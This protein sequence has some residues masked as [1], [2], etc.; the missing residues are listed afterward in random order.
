MGVS[1]KKIDL[2]DLK[3][4][5]LEQNEVDKAVDIFRE[6]HLDLKPTLNRITIKTKA[7]K[8]Y[9]GDFFFD[10]LMNFEQQLPQMSVADNLRFTSGYI[11]NITRLINLCPDYYELYFARARI[12]TAA[13]AAR[14]HFLFEKKDSID[15]DP[16]LILLK[17]EISDS[18]SIVR[19]NLITTIKL[20]TKF[21]MSNPYRP[22]NFYRTEI[23]GILAANY[24]RW[25]FFIARINPRQSA[26]KETKEEI[27]KSALL[28]IRIYQDI[29][30][31][32]CFPN[33]N[34]AGRLLANYANAMKILP[35]AKKTGLLYYETARKICGD[36]PEIL[37]GIDYYRNLK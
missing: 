28:A 10:A 8:E 12:M 35:D 23:R 31:N 14:E 37:E 17:K 24:R 13:Y 5:I 25:A 27:Y 16:E 19:Q 30:E 3:V 29:F 6:A 11:N 7:G 36:K 22:L 21:F 33:R 18:F 1:V 4:N 2:A 20:F 34:H 9:T 26:D 32:E 15:T